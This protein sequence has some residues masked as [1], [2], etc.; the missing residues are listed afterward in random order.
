M[1]CQD[2]STKT[3]LSYVTTLKMSQQILEAS[4]YNQLSS[5]R[6]SGV[7][8]LTGSEGKYHAN[9]YRH[10]LRNTSKRKKT[11]HTHKKILP[12][13]DFW[14]NWRVQQNQL[15]FSSYPRCGKHIVTWL[16]QLLSMFP[17]VSL[18]GGQLSRKSLNYI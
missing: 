2:S 1:F 3:K 7:N 8:D 9:C 4:H 5:I 6:L 10:F 11:L 13:N 17:Y 15:K 12:C 18:V 16:K 14:K